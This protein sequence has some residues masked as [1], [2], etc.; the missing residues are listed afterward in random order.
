MLC[1][2]QDQFALS[3][4]Q[5]IKYQEQSLAILTKNQLSSQKPAAQPPFLGKQR[6]NRSE[7][8]T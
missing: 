7:L 1:H 3:N 6:P 4:D 8:S 2:H 5:K